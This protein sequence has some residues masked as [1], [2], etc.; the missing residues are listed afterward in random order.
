[1]HTLIEGHWALAQSVALVGPSAT[2]RL[3]QIRAFM[4][5]HRMWKRAGAAVIPRA[6]DR[7]AARPRNGMTSSRHAAWW[8][9]PIQRR[10]VLFPPV[11]AGA[12]AGRRCRSPLATC[13]ARQTDIFEIMNPISDLLEPRILR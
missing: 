10:M 11:H 9:T 3:V 8:I 1:M 13:E 7:R 2:L 4:A 6:P 12:L 5:R